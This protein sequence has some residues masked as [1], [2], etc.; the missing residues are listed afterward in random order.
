MFFSKE[1][2]CNLLLLYPEE[3]YINTM[4]FFLIF[5]IF[6]DQTLVQKKLYSKEW[7]MID[8]LIFFFF[9]R[10]LALRSGFQLY[11]AQTFTL[12]QRV[13]LQR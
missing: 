3:E 9:G 8:L 5:L 1:L 2:I 6:L 11:L 12:F 4:Q 10:F 7:F 13:K